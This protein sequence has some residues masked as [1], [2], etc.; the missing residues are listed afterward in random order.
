[1]FGKSV[2]RS[3]LQP[4]KSGNLEPAFLPCCFHQG[5]RLHWGP[6]RQRPAGTC[7]HFPPLLEVRHESPNEATRPPPPQ[8]QTWML[9]LDCPHSCPPALLA[10]SH[11]PSPAQCPAGLSPQ[12]PQI[13]QVPNLSSIPIPTVLLRY[14]VLKPEAL[15]PSPLPI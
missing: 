6:R 4:E 13:P 12:E 10:V 3:H 14:P 8:I 7:C 5:Q 2:L 1:M 11:A 9:A 15:P